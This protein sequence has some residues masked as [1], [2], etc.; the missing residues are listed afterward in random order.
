MLGDSLWARTLDD[1]ELAR[2]LRDAQQRRVPAEHWI[3]VIEGLVKMSVSQ[4]DACTNRA[5]QALERA[6]LL[7]VE[8]GGVTVPHLAGLRSF[9]GAAESA[10]VSDCRAAH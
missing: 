2:V 10:A 7:R 9:D 6:R 8:F 4:P 1:A 3:G 5:L